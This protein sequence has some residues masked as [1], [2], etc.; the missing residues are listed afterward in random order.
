MSG[1]KVSHDIGNLGR[2]RL[3]SII[4]VKTPEDNQRPRN[5]KSVVQPPTIK[6]TNVCTEDADLG[7]KEVFRKLLRQIYEEKEKGKHKVEE[8]STVRRSVNYER[9]HQ[10]GEYKFITFIKY[11]ATEHEHLLTL[12]I[13][14]PL[15][16]VTLYIAFIEQSPL[17]T[18]NR[19]T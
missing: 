2:R 18:Y 12:V 17:F 1:R 8:E 13:F 7:S 15:I 3:K 10:G 16:L 9:E 11:V 5:R 4:E 6:E 14:L 19:D